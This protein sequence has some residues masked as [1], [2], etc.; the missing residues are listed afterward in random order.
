VG[1]SGPAAAPRQPQA[2]NTPKAEE[3]L[4]LTRVTYL[5]RMF[6]NN[7]TRTAIFYDNVEVVNVPSDNPDLPI[8]IDHLP[9]GG[10]YLRCEQ[11]TVYSQKQQNGKAWQQMEAHRKAQVQ[12]REF[13]GRADII[14]YDESKEQVIF[15]ATEGNLATLYRVKARGLPADEIKGKKIT[16]WRRTNDFHVEGMNIMRSTD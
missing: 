12:S 1:K 10:L 6:A 15:E 3:E 9:E 11:L 13:W 7:N 8:D 2:P 14:K 16:Y 5:G 4:K